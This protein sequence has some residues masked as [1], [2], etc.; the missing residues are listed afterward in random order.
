MDSIAANFSGPTGG[1][2]RRHRKSR[3][4]CG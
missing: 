4:S 3:A 1:D 2:R